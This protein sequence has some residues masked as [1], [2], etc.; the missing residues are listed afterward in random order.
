MPER[1]VFG[2]ESNLH[3]GLTSRTL[4]G[5]RIFFG[6]IEFFVAVAA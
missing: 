1:V 3:V 4:N 2:D 5:S 6:D